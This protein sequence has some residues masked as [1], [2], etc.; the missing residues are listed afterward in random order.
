MGLR[1]LG[2]T[3]GG[4]FFGKGMLARIGRERYRTL[5]HRLMPG[6]RPMMWEPYIEKFQASVR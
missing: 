2:Q 1:H 6:N 3:G 4:A 5:C